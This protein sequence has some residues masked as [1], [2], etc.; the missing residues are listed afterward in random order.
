[1]IVNFPT[2]GKLE[3]ELDETIEVLDELYDALNEIMGH[4]NE[5]ELRA[6]EVEA[7]FDKTLATLIK[8]KGIQNV[9]ARYLDYSSDAET[10][11]YEYKEWQD[12]Q[13]PRSEGNAEIQQ[14]SEV[15]KSEAGMEE[16]RRD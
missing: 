3:K 8:Q 14:S 12:S 13:K 5:L 15:F 6:Y 1:M 16:D 2:K 7:G 10:Y 11:F 4:L 9:P